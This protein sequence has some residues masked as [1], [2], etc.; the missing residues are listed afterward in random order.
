MG[1]ALL[2]PNEDML[3]VTLAIKGIIDMQHCPARVSVDV[4]YPLVFKKLHN[5]LSAC[6]L[7]R[8]GP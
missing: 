5:N 7:H 6:E 1:C 2:V 4:L 3:Y 8:L